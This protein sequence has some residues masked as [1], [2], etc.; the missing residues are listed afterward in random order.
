MDLHSESSFQ[1]VYVGLQKRLKGT[2][3]QNTLQ[4]ESVA[5]ESK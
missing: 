2:R 5:L 1:D 3:A 4:N